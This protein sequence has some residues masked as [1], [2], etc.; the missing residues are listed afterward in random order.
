MREVLFVVR[1]STKD[2]V[3]SSVL[4][5]QERDCKWSVSA[6]G[7]TIP[8]RCGTSAAFSALATAFAEHA[9]T[10]QDVMA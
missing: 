6:D 9:R 8:G 1:G 7:F 3:T 10:H 2:G 4:C 5:C